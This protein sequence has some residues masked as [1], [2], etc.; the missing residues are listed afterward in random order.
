MVTYRHKI[1][2]DKIKLRIRPEDIKSAKIV[3]LFMAMFSV[4]SF[5]GY[6]IIQTV[7]QGFE[8]QK[9]VENIAS[10]V[11]KLEKENV[12]LKSE[13]D[14]AMSESEIEA[15]YRALGYK[16]PGEEVYIVSRTNAGNTENTSTETNTESTST[17][18]PNWQKWIMLIFN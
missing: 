7:N 6:R 18:I 14:T 5:F 16:K 9:R 13:R 12:M 11:E 4:I 10:Q 17:E 15:Q 3:L 8:S 1:L 2:L